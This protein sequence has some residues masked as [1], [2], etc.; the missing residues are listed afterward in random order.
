MNRQKVQLQNKIETARVNLNKSIEC[1]ENYDK[2]Y[3]Y[4]VEL[5]YL[6][7]QYLELEK[8]SAKL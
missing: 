2:I 4:S 6:I 8:E 1:G 5:D 7:V 3:E